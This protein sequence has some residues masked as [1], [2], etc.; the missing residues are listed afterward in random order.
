MN[1]RTQ[2]ESYL[3]QFRQR[4]TRL[5]VARGAALLAVTA[6]L[7]TLVAVWFGTRRAFNDEFMLGA[8]LVLLGAL[9]AIAVGLVV[10]P[11]RALKRNRAIAEI[12]RRAPDFDGRIETY[13]D[14]A[15]SGRPSPFLGLLAKD[16]LRFA[17]KVPVM[18]GVTRLELSI[19]TVIS[20]IAVVAL[21]S[22][23]IVGPGNWRYGVRDLW[24]GWFLDDTLPP[25]FISTC[26]SRSSC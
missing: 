26:P 4:L 1:A 19:P 23:A 20:G 24:A 14:L 5:T 3:E 16:A 18:L 21:L 17:Q 2:L 11:L 15:A 6:L 9:V 25:Q 8:R 12:E 10:L 22:A 7:L 13:E